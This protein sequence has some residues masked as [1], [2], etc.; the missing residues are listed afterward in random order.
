[1]GNE[2]FL[3]INFPSDNPNTCREIS[4]QPPN[5]TE[6]L[7]SLNNSIGAFS[8]ITALKIALSLQVFPVLNAKAVMQ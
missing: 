2:R 8:P 7:T 4:A 6:R 3:N 1:M 5:N